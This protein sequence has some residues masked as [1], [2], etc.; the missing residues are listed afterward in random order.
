MNLYIM[1]SVKK[2]PVLLT[3]VFLFSS[4]IKDVD[5]EQINDLT[6]APTFKTSLAHFTLN[7]ITFFDRINSL[8]IITPIN[9]TSSFLS[10][11]SS[12]VR[13]NL[14][15]MILDFEIN[16]EFNR[17]FRATFEFLDDNDVVTH[18]FNTFFIAAN[19]L[20]FTR[21]ERINVSGNNQFLSST[22]IRV[23]I[24]LRP[25]NNGAVI[26][27]NIEKKLVF[28]TAGTFFLNLQ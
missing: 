11:K 12:F 3:V 19:N 25:S 1:K 28:K 14:Q 10:L 21:Q 23:F 6:S 18:S 22:K 20:K 2:I 5:F 26:N 24:E 4:C 15:Q 17:E 13:E 9:R 27:P 16:N 8:E 7:Q